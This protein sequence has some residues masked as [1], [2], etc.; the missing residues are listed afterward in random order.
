MEAKILPQLKK[1]GVKYIYCADS[2]YFK[3]LVKN[4]KIDAMIGYGTPCSIPGYEDIEI[5][6]GINYQALL[7][8]PNQADKL[9]MSVQALAGKVTNSYKALGADIL[10]WALYPQTEKEINEAFAKLMTYPKLTCDIETFSLDIFT[11]GIGTI[12][13]SPDNTGGIA[14]SCDHA[15]RAGYEPIVTPAQMLI[16]M[17]KESDLHIARE[18]LKNQFSP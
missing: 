13:F 7:Y 2:T 18:A 11:A 8:N 5:L 14:F 9:E 15:Y 12:A 3:C 16:V 1:M 17:I 4:A 6:V 10:K